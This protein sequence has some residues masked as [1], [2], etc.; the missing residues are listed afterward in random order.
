MTFAIPELASLFMLTF[1]RVGTL[2]MLLPGT[3][4]RLVPARLRLAF[5]FLLTL[6]L[7]PIVRNLFPAGDAPQ[8]VIGTMIGEVAIG[9]MLG[10]A[11][12]MV[13][14]AL[15]TAGNIVAQELG[16]SFAMTI[17]PTQGGGQEAAIGN[18]LTLLGITLVFAT[19]LHH[20][21]IAAIG[22][23]YELLP[24]ARLP[25]AGDAAQ[26]AIGAVG[27]AFRLA[28]QISAPFI[29]FAF[30]FNLGLGILSR[31][32]PQMQVF[33]LA[34][35]LTILIGVLVLLAALGMMM[36]VYLGQLGAFLSQLGMG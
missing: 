30:L 25:E 27:R 33:F 29:A 13:V 4:E 21:A 10:L 14:S 2:V 22:N 24:P 36:S 6:L 32:M 19:D 31:L 28:V 23:S 11:T 12:R 9:L 26:L 17:D 15:Q 16:L 1:A 18:F 8:V 35:P 3:G 34:M 7:L 5:A 20:L